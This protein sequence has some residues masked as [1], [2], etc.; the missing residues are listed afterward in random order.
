MGSFASSYWPFVRS[1]PPHNVESSLEF[2][3]L[4]ALEASQLEL[5]A[6]Q[7]P[8]PLTP[9]LAEFLPPD[10]PSATPRTADSALRAEAVKPALILSASSPTQTVKATP[11]ENKLQMFHLSIPNVSYVNK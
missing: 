9:D 11:S 4:V 5:V 1:T 3:A 10:W 8:D 7:E 6:V 2:S